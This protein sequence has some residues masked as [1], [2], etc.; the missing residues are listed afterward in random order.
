MDEKRSPI[1]AGL[2][3]AAIATALVLGGHD[4]TTG[5]KA[6]THDAATAQHTSDHPDITSNQEGPWYA[7]CQEYATTEF[8]HGEDPAEQR[9]IKGHQVPDGVEDGTTEITRNFRDQKGQVEI[10]KFNVRKHT[11]GEL[12][13][14]V[15]NGE[16]LRVAIAMVPDPNAT[17]MRLDFDRDIV[18][19]QRAAAAEHYLYERYWFPWRDKNWT[20]ERGDDSDAETRRRQEPGIL[21][22]RR[23]KNDGSTN[24]L[25]ILLV[26]ETPTSGANRIQLAH[27]L[28]YDEELTGR[29]IK[30][31]ADS[32]NKL[33]QTEQIDI[34]GPHFSASFKSIRDVLLKVKQEHADALAK[35][36]EPPVRPVPG[37]SQPPPAMQLQKV[38]FISP[39]ASGDEFINEFRTFCSDQGDL[40]KLRTLSLTSSDVRSKTLGFLQRLGYQSKYVAQ[41]SEDESAFGI[42][43][44]DLDPSDLPPGVHS[45]ASEKTD[46]DDY[47]LK[48]HFPRDLSSVRNLSDEQSEKVAEAG[49]KY[50]SLPGGSLPTQLSAQEP[51][52]RD[53]PSAY[54]Q[55]QE[56]A[57]VARSLEQ[58]VEEM[59]IH[60]IRAVV[61]SASNP[62]D[63]IYL[64]EYLHNQLP[65]VRTVTTEADTLELDRPH[66]IDLT[67]TIAVTPLPPFEGMANSIQDQAEKPLHVSFA[68]SRQEG[69]FLAIETLLERNWK[70][71]DL[72][73]NKDCLN[74]SVVG[75]T[76]F[77]PIPTQDDAQG[78]L[79]FPCQVQ[80]SAFSTDVVRTGTPAAYLTVREHAI[81]PREYL[82][83]TGVVILLNFIHGWSLIGSRRGIEGLLSYASRMTA[84]L[85]PRRLYLLFAI[86][87]QLLILDI[88][89]SRLAYAYHISLSLSHDADVLLEVLFM[90]VALATV[91]TA[92]TSTSLGLQF[93]RSL[94]IP[95]PKEN[96]KRDMASQGVIA[97][98]YLVSS[99]WM[100]FELQITGAGGGV[101]LERMTHLGDGLS[102][103][104]PITAILLG[105]FFWGWVQLKRLEWSS[106]RKAHLEFDESLGRDLHSAIDSLEG[107]V[108]ELSPTGAHAMAGCSVLAVCTAVVL[109]HRLN[110][111]DG[112]GFSLWFTAWGVIMLLLTV[113]L[114]TV[115]IWSIW[116]RIR[117][118][119]TLLGGT[120][121]SSTFK[122]LADRG[123][124]QVKVW[125]LAKTGKNFK[126]LQLT[127]DSIKRLS[128]TSSATTLQ[129]K[130]QLKLLL[131]MDTQNQQL[132]PDQIDRFSKALNV[133]MN[134][135]VTSLYSNSANFASRRDDEL[136]A[137]LALR[138]VA[139]IRYG[140]LH[141]GAMIG[142][143]AYG[144]VL[145]VGSIMFYPFEGRKTIGEL[146]MLSFLGLLIWIGTMMVQFQRNEM[147]SHL[148]GS[149]PGEANYWQVVLH[150]VT[151]G[152]LPLIA[153]LTSQF[154]GIANFAYTF[155]RPLLGVLH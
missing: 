115:H 149:K 135:A 98:L 41:L 136:Q 46:S 10:E 153:V 3:G 130:A 121:M 117:D 131:D 133:P 138:L 60:L 100:V 119:L 71:G 44:I 101:F 53:S 118:L 22:F 5:P 9:G 106:S 85:E 89:I 120:S 42:S 116:R 86:N 20:P 134:E 32:G 141:I 17:Q 64:L 47:G 143:V 145:A 4:S 73:D 30:N 105:Y 6:Q 142:F 139:L 127:T 77:R 83:F 72:A 87:N 81:A 25:F 99:L 150:L 122:N 40:C 24:R 94:Q 61:I 63:R 23:Q 79:R 80:Q 31:S 37:R 151:V 45:P 88:L 12:S 8:D 75:G 70:V 90:L 114:T 33:S 7:F 65:D 39:D 102:P 152:G 95:E 68:S 113:T 13:S 18:A 108:D 125:D 146:L 129:A 148:D 49:S 66:F 28:Y 57:E 1:F 107:C 140:M 123:T 54:G 34:S 36:Q 14:C 52:D 2:G 29:R 109:W 124:M 62:L 144:F 103:V 110:G 16:A 21:C 155:F 76:G 111:F 15:P 78:K 27:A 92:V 50:F 26:G 82:T 59:R 112:I 93:V 35:E 19:I 147:L 137:Y 154:P 69:E 51:I 11:V 91:A 38:S 67:G 43:L 84:R 128:S 132:A 96:F 126:V 55:E 48:L 74:L 104:M 97:T 56:P 58:S